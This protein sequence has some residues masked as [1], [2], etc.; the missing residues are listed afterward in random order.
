MLGSD[1]PF[2]HRGGDYAYRGRHRAIGV[3][4]IF[5]KEH[6]TSVEKSGQLGAA[7]IGADE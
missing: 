7:A 5:S 2:H 1:S 3:Q 4:R 6:I